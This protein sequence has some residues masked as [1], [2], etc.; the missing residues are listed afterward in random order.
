MVR[1]PRRSSSFAPSWVKGV[2]AVSSWERIFAVFRFDND[3]PNLSVRGV[4]N[5]KITGFKNSKQSTEPEANIGCVVYLLCMVS[6]ESRWVGFQ[7]HQ[8]G[9]AI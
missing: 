5:V 2:P 7:E 1:I 8:H 6:Q 3:L 4:R 9:S